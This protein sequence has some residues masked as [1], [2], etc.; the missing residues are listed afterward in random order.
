MVIGIY[1]WLCSHQNHRITNAS[2][3]A[4][5]V[6]SQEILVVLFAC[7]IYHSL[8]FSKF[9][10]IASESHGTIFDI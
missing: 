4:T 7:E 8:I 2:Y 6:S 3:L 10:S 5:E 1:I 9:D